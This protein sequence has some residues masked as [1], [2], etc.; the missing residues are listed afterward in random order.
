MAE[1]TL[2][3]CNVNKRGEA[4]YGTICSGQTLTNSFAQTQVGGVNQT[5]NSYGNRFIAFYPVIVKNGGSDVRIQIFTNDAPGSTTYAPLSTLSVASGEVTTDGA[6]IIFP[7]DTSINNVFVI[8]TFNALNDSCY[9]KIKE[10]TDGGT[11]AVVTT[12]K[13]K[14]IPGW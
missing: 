9:I 4:H 14:L 8:D 5:F 3:A 12:L 7:D 6:E 10:G 1:T 2:T 11:D 13:I